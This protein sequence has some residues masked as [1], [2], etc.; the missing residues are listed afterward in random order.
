VTAYIESVFGA[1]TPAAVM[2]LGSPPVHISATIA[3]MPTG[4]FNPF[5]T[6]DPELLAMYGEAAAADEAER[7]ELNRQIVARV[8]EQA[9]FAPVTYTPVYVYGASQLGGLVVNEDYRLLDPV[10]IFSTE[11]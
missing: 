10:E 5:K 2:G 1:T 3:L 4:P 6:E 7:V 8:Q 9:W 11:C